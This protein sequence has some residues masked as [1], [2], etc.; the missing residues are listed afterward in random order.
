M[1]FWESDFIP[2]NPGTEEF[3]PGHLLLPLSRYK[4]TPGHENFFV[5]RQWDNGTSLTI[6]YLVQ[7]LSFKFLNSAKITRFKF[8]FENIVVQALV[9]AY[10][11]QTMY[12]REIISKNNDAQRTIFP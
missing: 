7:P 6:I 3:V 4:G 9:G 11:L 1:F 5:P 10:L 2:G 8:D 12:V